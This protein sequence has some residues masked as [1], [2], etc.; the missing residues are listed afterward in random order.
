MRLERVVRRLLPAGLVG[1]LLGLL[2]AAF[3]I[4]VAVSENPQCEFVCDGAPDYGNIALLGVSWF[5]PTMLIGMLGYA[6]VRRVLRP[7]L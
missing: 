7:R 1:G 6:L 3:M 4:F 5:I 2:V